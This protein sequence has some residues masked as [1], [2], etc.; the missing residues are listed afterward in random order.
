M[1]PETQTAHS[2]LFVRIGPG[3]VWKASSR[4]ITGLA[5][6]MLHCFFYRDP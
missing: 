5:F 2:G 6:G 3:C 1:T 4:S